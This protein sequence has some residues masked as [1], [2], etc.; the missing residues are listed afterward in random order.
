[1]QRIIYFLYRNKNFILF[2]LLLIFCL[3]IN[4]N[5][6]Q[7]NKSKFLNSSNSFFSGV[8]NV[9]SNISKYFNLEYQNKLLLENRRLRF[10]LYNSKEKKI[11]EFTKTNFDVISG[12]V[13]KN[14]YSYS[15]IL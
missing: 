6:S 12:S 2:L 10:K 11:D 8:Y 7:Y 5:F 15:K 9:K 3:F 14:T 4:I 1:M 13:I